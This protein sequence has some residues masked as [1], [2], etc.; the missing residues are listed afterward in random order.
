MKKTKIIDNRPT[1]PE[2]SWNQHIIAAIANG[3]MPI[4][5]QIC[6][7]RCDIYLYKILLSPG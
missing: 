3:K 6:V 5:V 2:S 7:H 1:I 4:L